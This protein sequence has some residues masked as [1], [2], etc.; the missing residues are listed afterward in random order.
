MTNEELV[1]LIVEAKASGA[2]ELNL[3]KKGLAKLPPELFQLTS[4]IALDLS[5][6]QLT[7]LSPEI[8]RLAKR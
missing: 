7:V 8:S 4:L 6:N 3:R 1:E 2:H 5:C